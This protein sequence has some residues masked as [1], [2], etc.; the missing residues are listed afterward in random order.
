MLNAKVST[1]KSMVWSTSGLHFVH[2][3]CV[4]QFCC[5]ALRTDSF[6]AVLGTENMV[7]KNVFLVSYDVL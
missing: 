7:V 4:F 1:N 6:G 3:A 2:A 5:D